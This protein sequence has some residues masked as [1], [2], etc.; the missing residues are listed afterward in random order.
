MRQNK[1]RKNVE[2]ELEDCIDDNVI[3]P[4]SVF[5]RSQAC[6]IDWVLGIL[7][8]LPCRLPKEIR[9]EVR[10][11]TNEL[12]MTSVPLIFLCAHINRLVII[13]IFITD[14]NLQSLYVIKH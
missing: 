9:R 5:K 14:D 2:K 3:N 12:A 10:G 6:C 7:Q 11:N 13:V 4:L 1:T 8:E